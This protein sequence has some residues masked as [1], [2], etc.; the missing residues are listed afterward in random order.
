MKRTEYCN[1]ASYKEL[2]A[3]KRENYKALQRKRSELP[4]HAAALASSL[5][6]KALMDKL[7]G[8]ISPLRAV[9]SL[10]TKKR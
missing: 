6:P 2:C 7:L 3:V 10:F 5:S 4:T 9:Y 1:I 8:Y